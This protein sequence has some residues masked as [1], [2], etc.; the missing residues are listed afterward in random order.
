M[1]F[2]GRT[3][4]EIPDIH[5]PELR[6]ANQLLSAVCIQRAM[7]VIKALE[8]KDPDN[9]HVNYVIA[10]YS[11][12][13][14]KIEDAEM[15]LKVTLWKHPDFVSAKVLLAGI[16][17]EQNRIDEMVALL[18]EVESS[19]PTDVWVMLNRMRVE[20][21]RTPSREL[22]TR[23]MEMARSTAFP[24][25]VRATAI[26][27]A[28]LVPDQSAAEHDEILRVGLDTGHIRANAGNAVELAT[29]LA[30]EGKHAEVRA[31]LESP[32]AV[33]EEWLLFT[34][35]RLLLAQAYLMEAASI[36]AQPSAANE[37]QI[38][39]ADEI[40][41]GDYTFFLEW[42]SLNPKSARL[43]PFVESLVKMR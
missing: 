25:N 19:V 1:N 21:L 42:V 40:L 27:T 24:P 7:D 17:F 28:K 34:D 35:N 16:R 4:E 30:D 2:R 26:N 13:T 14:S 12:I 29:R 22:R 38:S 5:E 8:Q 33:E 36:S 6:L 43:K 20:A 3:Y 37:A 11:W 15:Q 10:R 18:D 39:R 9:H 23:L 32:R 41:D 31:L